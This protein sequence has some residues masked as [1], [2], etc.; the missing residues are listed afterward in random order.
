MD[1]LSVKDIENR[2]PRRRK[3]KWLS[4]VTY[5][6][7]MR[8]YVDTYIRPYVQSLP[9]TTIDVINEITKIQNEYVQK[10]DRVIK[11]A[12]V[13]FSIGGDVYVS[14]AMIVLDVESGGKPYITLRY[15]EEGFDF[16]EDTVLVK[17]LRWYPS[18]PI[19]VKGRRYHSGTVHGVK[20]H[21]PVDYQFTE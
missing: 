11:T 10:L 8:Q 20:L 5:E 6:D 3:W 21:L 2:K 12:M 14:K 9:I 19:L 16:L 15:L 13:T 17:G 18:D 7:E 4:G 1:S